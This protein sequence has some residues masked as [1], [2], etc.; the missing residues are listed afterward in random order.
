MIA[1]V[2]T[3]SLLALVRYYLPF[4]LNGNLK[5][6][7]ADKFNNGEIIIIDKV[8]EESKYISQGLILSELDFIKDKSVHYKTNNLFPDKTFF[9]LLDN[10]FCD[11]AI[12]KAKDISDVEFELFQKN[13]IG[14]ADGSI[15]LVSYFK[16]NEDIVVVTEESNS[17][18][19]NK[20][21]KKIPECCSL[22]NIKHCSLPVLIMDYYNI[23][24]SSY[25]K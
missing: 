20:L 13:Y 3:S 24:L 14:S 11:K 8:F 9:N 25:L 17:A 2:D 23:E 16:K 5:G 15:L 4:D 21:F 22:I 10:Q 18:N 1:I 19:D 7:I 12:R 6:L